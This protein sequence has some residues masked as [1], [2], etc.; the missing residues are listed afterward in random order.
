M[1]RNHT[2]KVRIK[3]ETYKLNP[4]KYLH[5]HTPPCLQTT[6]VRSGR[7]LV[8][9]AGSFDSTFRTY[10]RDHL[11]AVCTCLGSARVAFRKEY[12]LCLKREKKN[13][14]NDT[15]TV[16]LFLFILFIILFKFSEI[17]IHLLRY[18]EIAPKPFPYLECIARTWSNLFQTLMILKL[19]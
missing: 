13:N 3:T 14:F 12:F 5:F 15:F 17:V 18:Q 2:K 16:T 8:L 1:L 11:F 9:A 10:L 7:I 4:K 6:T 19:S